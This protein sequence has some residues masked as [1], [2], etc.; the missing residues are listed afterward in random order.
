MP[1]LRDE[2]NLL[3]TVELTKEQRGRSEYGP[4][5]HCIVSGQEQVNQTACLQPP[6][7]FSS[8]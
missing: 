7:S 5:Q 2:E 3:G 6:D 1:D 8:T 4:V